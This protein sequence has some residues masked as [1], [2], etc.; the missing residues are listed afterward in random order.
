MKKVL[1]MLIAVLIMA[2]IPINMLA[3]EEETEYPEEIVD[4]E[5]IYYNIDS[6]FSS[7]KEVD[8]ITF[9]PNASEKNCGTYK[10][11]TM[12]PDDPY[13]G[14]YTVSDN[15]CTIEGQFED[16]VYQID[17]DYLVAHDYDLD[18]IIPDEKTFDTTIEYN[19]YIG[20]TYTYTFD[21][22]GTFSC[23][24]H[25]FDTDRLEA[26]GTYEKEGDFLI[27]H[28]NDNRKTV[29]LVREG[30]ACYVAYVR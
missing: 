26:E 2:I 20:L 10:R 15:L 24:Y 30:I 21:K 25:S 13:I 28:H 19:R 5:G 12:D 29:L 7:Y 18:G 14:K 22:D 6:Y 23:E 9:T 16:T 27:L 8:Y 3:A 11:I 1:V 4:V 17:G